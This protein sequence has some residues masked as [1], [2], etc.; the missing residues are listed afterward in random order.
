MSRANR[1]RRRSGTAGQL[2]WQ[3]VRICRN[4]GRNLSLIVGL[5]LGAV[6]AIAPPM[7]LAQT[8]S[9]GYTLL[10]KGWVNDAIKAFQQSLMV[11]PQS[12]PDRLGLAVAYQRAGQ[13]A[14]AWMN[15]LQVLQRDPQNRTALAAVGTLGGYRPEWQAEGIA[16]LTTLLTLT[17]NDNSVRAQRA[18]LYG[19][20]GR[21]AESLTD[22]QVVLQANPAPA[23]LLGAAQIN[24]YSG[25]YPQG[26]A[27][28]E[29]YLKTGQAIPDDALPA[30]AT[31]LRET[32][33][34][35][36]AIKLLTQ[37]LPQAKA[38]AIELRTALAL[39]YQA[40][41]Q[42]DAATEVLAPLRNDPQ[43][44]LPLAR[45]L[46][47]MARQTGDANWW[48]EAIDLYQR[49]YQQTP[50]P[51][52]GFTTEVAD[53][54]SEQPASRS[55]ALAL[56]QQLTQQQPNDRSL[57]VKQLGIQRQLGKLSRTELSQQ[58]QPLLQPLPAAA[59]ERQLLAR[60]LVRVDAPDASLLPAYQALLD[61]G[62]DAPFLSYRIAQMALQNGDFGAA[63]QAVAN[64]Q[65]VVGPQDLAPELLLAEIERRETKLPESAQRY[66]ALIAR[67]PAAAIRANAL[68]GLAGVRQQ[69]GRLADAIQLY[70]QLL[71]QDPQDVTAQLGKASLAYQAQQITQAEA[72]AVLQKGL[73]LVDEGVPELVSLVGAL[74][75]DPSREAL[76]NSLLVADPEN[77]AVQRRL[78]QVLAAR[79][80]AQA[81]S[82]VDQLIK[83]DPNS[84]TA[85]FIQGEL[86]RSLGDLNLAG[87]AY[88]TILQRQPNNIDGLY[89]LGGV[90]FEQRRLNEARTIYQ[91]ILALKPQD[92]DTRRILGELDLAQDLPFAA[93]QQFRTIRQEQISQNVADA[94]L[95]DRVIRIEVD[96]LKRR[97]FQPGWERY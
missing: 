7:T 53:V 62:V 57:A 43:A 42:T 49:A 75:A 38:A 8:T 86:G 1:A 17:P 23:T 65:R 48:R 74:P 39:A 88:E 54:F 63:R 76:Y 20:Q 6:G 59:A 26:L 31:T 87:Q 64:Y 52:T 50:N 45:A 90:R 82:R 47:T 21:F 81:R 36:A 70:E 94:K 16:A 69:Q 85:Y 32:G 29:R 22:Y 15:Y 40:S 95:A 93:L 37:R 46:S 51:P 96:R 92:W 78:I 11:N 56:Y 83:Q 5:S 58:L 41:G 66:E 67:N 89:A 73:P 28:F 35:T 44:V 24:T 25:D 91:R 34:P 97:G 77:L 13:D 4:L 19:Y 60:A 71:V 72:E 10:N 18:L 55:A 12:V 30:Y 14:N 27:L 61:S 33:N 2:C 9:Q 80:P 84:L 79:D 68:R 3:S